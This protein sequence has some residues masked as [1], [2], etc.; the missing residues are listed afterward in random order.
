MTCKLVYH[1][2]QEYHQAVELRRQVLRFPLGLDFTTEQLE[3]EIDSFHFVGDV[4]GIVLATAMATPQDIEV[5]KIRQVAV[6]QTQQGK[7]F[8]Q[9]I[10]LFAEGWATQM[11]YKTV[12]LH[13]R[14]VVVEFYLKL[15]YELFDE[16]FE[17]VGIPHRKMR[18]SLGP[19]TS[20]PD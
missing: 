13:A 11:E 14:E 20:N 1:G 10:M 4:E 16:P 7:G 5:I 12:V 2:S 8:G 3:S 15:G 18:K 17:E 6:S 9:E 19:W